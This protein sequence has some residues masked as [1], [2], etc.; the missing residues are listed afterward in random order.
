M[1]I[2][3]F[4]HV[5]RGKRFKIPEM[6]VEEMKFTDELKFRKG[7]SNRRRLFWY[8]VLAIAIAEILS[9]YLLPVTYRI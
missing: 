6:K 1:Y 3:Q 9:H 7:P 8:L 2:Y 4:Y 5:E